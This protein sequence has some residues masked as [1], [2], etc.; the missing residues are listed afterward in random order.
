MIIIK[1]LKETDKTHV[2]C[3]VN[4]L[5]IKLRCVCKVL[6]SGAIESLY[7]SNRKSTQL[8]KVIMLNYRHVF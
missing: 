7:Q 5:L 8:N 6:S 2:L 3:L 1:N 4:R